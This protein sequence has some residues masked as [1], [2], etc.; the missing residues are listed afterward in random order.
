VVGIV[1]I[2]KTEKMEVA[3]INL[4]NLVQATSTNADGEV[5]CKVMEMAIRDGN[6]I[7]LSLMDASPFSSSF[8]NSSFGA[9]WENFGDDTL[10][11]RVRITNYQP[12]RRDQIFDY[13]TKLR[14][15]SS[16]K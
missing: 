1:L 9:L 7:E 6:V 5:L 4:M 15:V 11:G 14:Q 12:T 13:L 10:K 2:L 16:N 8:L 3:K